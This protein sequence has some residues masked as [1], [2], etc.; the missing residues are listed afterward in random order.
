MNLLTLNPISSCNLSCEHCPNK[1]WTYPIDDTEHNR[2]NNEIIFQWMAKYTNPYEW[3]LEISGGEPGVYPGISELVQELSRLGYYGIIR[4]NGTMP[5][6]KTDTFIRLAGWH[7]QIRLS[8][9]PKNCDVMLITKNPKDCWQDKAK[10]C[11]SNNILYKCIEYKRFGDADFIDDA[12]S[13]R[14]ESKTNTFFTHWTIV[15]SSGVQGYCYASWGEDKDNICNM[16]PP[17]MKDMTQSCPTCAGTLGILDFMDDSL[18][19]KLAVRRDRYVYH[20]SV[21]EK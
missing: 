9:P 7:K 1:E 12:D 18:R 10:Y 4:T 5:I 8:T 17:L 16:S 13:S 2:L 19:Q 15:G 14:Y 3:F 11:Q 21:S 20:N 6:P